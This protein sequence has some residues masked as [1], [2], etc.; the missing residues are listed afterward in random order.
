[1]TRKDRELDEEIRSHIEMAARDRI[2]RG[3]SPA[4]AA[5]EARR[6]FGNVAL[7][8]EVTREM[9]GGLWLERLVQD[10]RYGARLLRRTPSFTIV[11]VLSLALG[12]G[13]N[14]AIFQVIDAV[15]LRALPVTDPGALA[16]IQIA[17]MEGA[18]GS[19][20]SPHPTV[21][22]P[23]WE[24]LR[25]DQ[26]AFSGVLAWNRGT[27][28][29]T[30]GGVARRVRGLWVSGSFFDVLGVGPAAGRL[31]TPADDTRGCAPRAVLSHGFWQREFGGRPDAIGSTLTLDGLRVEVIGISK[32]GFNGVEVGRGFDIAVPICSEP[33]FSSGE[34]RLAS[35]TDWW[36][37]VMGRL[38]H[39]WTIDAASEH[40]ATISPALFGAT[41]APN[42]PA[43]SVAQYR[44]F[45]LRATAGALG[46]SGLREYY[47]TPLLL[48][49]GIAA[50]VL[51]IACVNLANLLLARASAREREFSVRLGLGASRGRIVRQLLVESMLLA[52]IG[53]GCGAFLASFLS[54]SLVGLLDDGEQQ[55]LLDLG[56][57]VRVLAFTAG[58]AVLT[59]LLFGL[60]PAIRATRAGSDG[61]LRGAGRGLTASRERFILR[62][63]LVTLQV[64]LAVLLVAGAALFTRT[65]VNLSNVD[66]GFDAD[67]VV[68]A[69]LDLRATH[70]ARDAEHALHAAL[71]DRLRAVPGVQGV[72][73]AAVV[74]ISG[75]SWGNRVWM[76]GSDPTR[77]TGT[78]FN[79]V[80]EDYFKTLGI[81]LAAGR[82]FSPADTLASTPI[83]IVD[84]TFARTLGGDNPVGRRFKVEPTPSRPQEATYEIVGVARNSTYY[85]LR[86]TPRPVAYLCS[87]QAPRAGAFVRLVARHDLPA[88][89]LASTLAGAIAEVHPGIVVSFTS[90]KAQMSDRLLRERLMATLSGFFGGV[91]ALLAVVGLYGVIAYTVA[92]RTKEIGIRI[93]LGATRRVVL[94]GVMREAGVLI[95]V[96]VAAGV[97]MA[98]QGSR[99]AAQLLF[100]LEPGDPASLAAAAISLAGVAL[101]ASYLPA[102][103]AANIE[104]TVA[105]RDE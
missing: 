3:R 41:I 9:W 18:R 81:P 79:R 60:A 13:A 8:K 65:L 12:I 19:F 71:L 99:M 77:T 44:A 97:I 53:A 46:T 54:R 51:I 33:A 35:G 91:A 98:L 4:A 50:I 67:G 32:A 61:L 31:L 40:L 72:A 96:G 37:I 103:A 43:A 63:G 38:K 6:E 17:D 80:S 28:N 45:K 56:F 86:E 2:D 34:G 88:T 85:D 90:L 10:L 52:S 93:A 58:A 47:R 26:Q 87:R 11:A 29:L 76:E 57:D 69:S 94:R 27:F 14:T 5:H 101:A 62:R 55:V 36:L 7:V 102:R 100:Q 83:A 70:T 92:R 16:H 21:T 78:S 49:L 89:Q 73:S 20:D 59:C 68:A 39:G 15:R 64:A 74:P 30:P 104:P 48:L 105:L 1:M 23:I 22:N 75:N 66:P 24:Q 95:G 82:D 42:Y 84:E 25:A